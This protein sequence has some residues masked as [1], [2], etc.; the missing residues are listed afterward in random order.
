M[1][2]KSIKNLSALLFSLI[3]Q[4]EQQGGPKAPAP[5][6]KGPTAPRQRPP[7]RT[8]ALV[9]PA[10]AE[11]GA[12][13][14][15][16]VS[17]ATTALSSDSSLGESD[18]LSSDEAPCDGGELRGA[19]AGLPAGQPEWTPMAPTADY[20]P[21]MQALQQQLS[22]LLRD[23]AETGLDLDMDLL[24]EAAPTLGLPPVLTA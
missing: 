17:P 14:P 5:Q 11:A 9:P 19:W 6:R 8:A 3:Q 23:A 15:R 24:R 13:W 10:A 2:L 20:W 22:A 1:K 7:P 21:R 12:E 4:L 18:G 16:A